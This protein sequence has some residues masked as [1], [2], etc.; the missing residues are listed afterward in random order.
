MKK[1]YKK[2][3]KKNCLAGFVAHCTDSVC[4]LC[5]GKMFG[6]KENPI[7]KKKNIAIW[8]Q[9]KNSAYGCIERRESMDIWSQC[10][11]NGIIL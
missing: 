1:K 5:S 3:Y 4:M 11:A 9:K 10:K 2:K 8:T 6:I 7:G